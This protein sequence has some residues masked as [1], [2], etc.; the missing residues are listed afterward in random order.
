MEIIEGGGSILG[1]AL[2]GV[3]VSIQVRVREVRILYV[4]YVRYQGLESNRSTPPHRN[5][6]PT[7]PHPILKIR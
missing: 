1:L 7:P 4:L 2:V 6:R 3:R 5:L